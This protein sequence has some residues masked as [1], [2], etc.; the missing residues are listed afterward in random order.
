M[1]E[2]NRT[3][4]GCLLLFLHCCWCNQ[5]YKAY[6]KPAQWKFI[7]DSIAFKQRWHIVNLSGS[8]VL[9]ST[10]SRRYRISRR[11]CLSL[12]TTAYVYSYVI[13]PHW[14]KVHKRL[15]NILSYQLQGK[16]IAVQSVVTV[17]WQQGMKL[18]QK[19]IEQN[20]IL[21]HYDDAKFRI[22]VSLIAQL[23]MVAHPL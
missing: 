23:I 11:S 4:S 15:K 6:S 5:T 22:A 2:I 13:D 7:T 18:H 10:P 9:K 16:K 12:P 17:V 20:Y 14:I 8:L 3:V 1:I 21:Q 19:K